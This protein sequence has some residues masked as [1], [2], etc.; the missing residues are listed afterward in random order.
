MTE[1]ILVTGGAGYVGSHVV[2]ELARAGYAPV[3]LDNFVNSTPAVLPRLQALA[4]AAGPVRDGRRPR[5]RSRCARSSTTIRSPRSSTAPGLKAVGESEA[6]PLAY[7]DVNV[8]GAH[9]ARRGDGRG[10][11]GDA[12]V[13]LVRDRLRPAR[14]PAGRPRTRRCGRRAST[15]AP[16]AWSRT[17]C[18]TSRTPTPTGASRSCATSIRP[19]RTPSGMLGEAPRG[20]PNNLVPLLCRIAGGEFAELAIYGDRLADARR[21]RHP[22]LPARA[23]PG[24]RPRRGAAATS[25]RTP[26]AVTLNLGRRARPLGAGSRGGVRAA[27]AAARSRKTIAP[28]RA[29]RRRVVLRRPVAR[30]EAAGVEGDA[31]PRHDLRRRVALAEERRQVLTRTKSRGPASRRQRFGPKAVSAKASE[32][33]GAFRVARHEA[34][35]S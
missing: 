16:S 14:R 18:A 34:R 15:G 21:H 27:R 6:R 3:V 25:P 9:R 28:R 26:G 29:G 17:S 11:R 31:R 1:T 33:P 24:R 22:R 8:G 30:G 20:R 13:Q 19:A 10:R 2:V 4:G 5:R 23:G 35:R 12:G 32:R 7:Y